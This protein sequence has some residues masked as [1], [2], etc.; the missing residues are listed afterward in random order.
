MKFRAVSEG[1]GGPTIDLNTHLIDDPTSTFLLR[2]SGD[3]MTGAGISDGDEVIVD[4]SK[5]AQHGSIVIAELDGEL[6]IKRLILN[7]FGRPILHAENPAYPD[8]IVPELGE[9]SVWGVVTVCLHH[10]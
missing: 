2:V 5:T 4:R 7:D 9:F 1:P 10:L 6:T 8:I 3:S